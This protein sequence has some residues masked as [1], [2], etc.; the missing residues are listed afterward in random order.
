[1][2]LTIISA[3]VFRSNKGKGADGRWLSLGPSHDYG[4]H[5]GVPSWVILFSYFHFKRPRNKRL[6]L[7]FAVASTPRRYLE[8]DPDN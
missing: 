5:C 8:G 3:V 1:M 7:A 6:G 2:P 4:I